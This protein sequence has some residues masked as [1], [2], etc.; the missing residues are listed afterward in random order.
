MENI[1]SNYLKSMPKEQPK[2]NLMK[3]L[4]F[5][6]SRHIF[7]LLRHLQLTVQRPSIPYYKDNFFCKK[8]SVFLKNLRNSAEPVLFSNLSQSL[9]LNSKFFLPYTD[10][11]LEEENTARA[12]PKELRGELSQESRVSP[13]V[14]YLMAS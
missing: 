1:C 13:T 5:L 11:R 10:F 7:S 4:C 9:G 2:H 14:C 6:A 8:F 12:M 3:I